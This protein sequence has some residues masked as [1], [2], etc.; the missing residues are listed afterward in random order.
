M[1]YRLKLHANDEEATEFIS[2]SELAKLCNRSKDSLKKLT[3]RGILPESNYRTSKS[4]ITVGA[5]KGQ[6]IK[7]HRLYSK[8][9]LAP[10]IAEFMGG[11]TQG[12]KI[13]TEQKMELINM[14]QA[15]KDNFSK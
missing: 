12:K 1:S 11:V 6:Y 9:F 13:T 3:E 7:G 4:L 8:N 5:K 2:M 15:E 14:F 10:K